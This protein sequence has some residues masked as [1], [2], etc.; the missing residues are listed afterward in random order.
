[1]SEIDTKIAFQSGEGTAETLWAESLGS[2][3][4]RLHN[5]PFFFY[6]VSYQDIVVATPAEDGMLEYQRTHEKGGHRTVRVLVPPVRLPELGE[7]MTAIAGMSCHSES[8]FNQLLAIDLPPEVAMDAI[9]DYLTEAGWEWE[10]ADPTQAQVD[11]QS[12]GA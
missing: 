9:C 6:G 1:M 5:T 12:T 10:H 4:Y 7:L 3:L 2:E 8:A 11:A